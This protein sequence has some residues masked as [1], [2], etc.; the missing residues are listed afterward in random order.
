MSK[1]LETHSEP[2][3]Q[4]EGERLFHQLWVW[5]N[6]SK[7]CHA[8]TFGLLVIAEG[9]WLI[10]GPI[11]LFQ[12]FVWMLAGMAVLTTI[13]LERLFFLVSDGLATWRAMADKELDLIKS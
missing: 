5:T 11:E 9:T 13:S 1:H 6:I 3:H 7:W 12:V 4:T 8:V 2:V 10:M